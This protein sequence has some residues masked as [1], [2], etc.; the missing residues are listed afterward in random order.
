MILP[1]N[2]MKHVL[3]VN[4]PHWLARTLA[5][6]LGVCLVAIIGFFIFSATITA[7]LVH[8][9]ALQGENKLQSQQIQSFFDK[10]NELETGIRELEQRDQELREMLGLQKP[11]KK[12]DLKINSI[13][14][15][16]ELTNRLAALKEYVKSKDDDYKLM[17]DASTALVYKFNS[18]PSVAPINSLVFSQM[19][20]R[21][22]PFSGKSEF[23]QGVDIP[24]WVG[25]P[26]RAAADGVVVYSAWA[27]GYGNMVMI[28][29]NNGYKTIYGHNSRLLVKRGDRIF[30][31]QVLAKAGSTGMST[32][33]HVHYQV[34]YDNK[35][36]N[37]N[38]F[39][40][41]N[42]SSARVGQ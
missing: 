8:Y 4:I 16:E 36:I 38:G 41:L 23:H 1:H 32:G 22:H 3:R 15:P 19:G 31:G 33:P 24:T 34:E 40:D 14:T 26:V 39:L 10:T 25:C 42:I 9:Y 35:V 29:H 20:W 30:K 5:A 21:T 13:S 18:M 11:A 27:N 6:L 2:S 12:K 7:R 17:K 37:P 28:D